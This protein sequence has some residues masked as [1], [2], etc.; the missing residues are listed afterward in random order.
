MIKTPVK[1]ISRLKED[2]YNGGS[3]FIAVFLVVGSWKLSGESSD[4]GR[5]G[6]PQWVGEDLHL[7]RRGRGRGVL[8]HRRPDSGRRAVPEQALAAGGQVEHDG[9]ERARERLRH[10]DDDYAQML[11]TSVGVNMT[12][13]E[14]M[15]S[16]S[17]EMDEETPLQERLNHLTSYIR[18]IGLIVSAAVLVV[19]LVRYF[20]GHTTDENG[21]REFYAGKTKID[22]I[23]NKVAN[24][25]ATAVTIVV[26]AIPEGLPPAITLTL[27]Y[28][29]M[30]TLTYSLKRMTVDQAMVRK[31]FELLNLMAKF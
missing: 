16:I 1:Y 4:I 30:F 31:L 23:L 21:N 22:A 20:T 17:R 10:E 19:V 11:I 13:G 8:E 12:W 27:A 15:S 7:R 6:R 26:V 9:R 18:K 24:I 28:S 5:G 25:F 14:T 2:W 29:M 3:I